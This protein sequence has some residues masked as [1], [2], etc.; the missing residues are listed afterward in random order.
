MYPYLAYPLQLP[1]LRKGE[2]KRL[3]KQKSCRN[4]GLD[5]NSGQ[6]I[7]PAET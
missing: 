2:G 7:T 4:K 6:I 3:E 1:N 5:F